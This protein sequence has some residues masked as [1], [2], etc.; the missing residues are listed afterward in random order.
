MYKGTTRLIR[1][2]EEEYN[3]DEGE[4]AVVLASDVRETNVNPT[5]STVYSI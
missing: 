3:K 2:N 1:M 5:A 4:T